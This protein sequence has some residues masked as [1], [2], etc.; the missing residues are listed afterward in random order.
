MCPSVD[1]INIS[2]A[3][4]PLNPEGQHSMGSGDELVD[5]NNQL[6]HSGFTQAWV[7]T[8][9]TVMIKTTQFKGVFIA[10]D[11]QTKSPIR[12]VYEGM[13]RSNVTFLTYFTNDNKGPY[14]GLGPTDK[15]IPIGRSSNCNMN[16]V[17]DCE[18]IHQSENH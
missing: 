18:F 12:C 8:S 17:H 7:Y 14:I 6:F 1:E 10:V 5:A 3:Q 4:S 2:V 16:D 13:D 15:W 9:P 11:K